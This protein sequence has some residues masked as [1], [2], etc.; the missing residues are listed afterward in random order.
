MESLNTTGTEVAAP[1]VESAPGRAREIFSALQKA[2]KMRKLYNSSGKPYEEAVGELSSRFAEYLSDEVALVVAVTLDA[3]VVEG[4][5]YMKSP[6]REGSIPFQLFRDGIRSIRILQGVP[7]EEVMALLDVLEFQ[8]DASHLDDDMAT[9]FWK[10]DFHAIEIT[11]FDDLGALSDVEGPGGEGR[12]ALGQDLGRSLEEVVESLRSCKLF[13]GEGRGVVRLAQ[14]SGGRLVGAEEREVLE[15]DRLGLESTQQEIDE[16]L[17]L[18]SEAVLERL[19]HELEV[20]TR[21]GLL[22]RVSDMVVHIL[23]EGQCT[24]PPQELS[25][26]LLNLTRSLAASGDVARINELLAKIDRRTKVAPLP[27]ASE[28]LVRLTEDL[29]TE[30]SLQVLFRGIGS[31]ERSNPSQLDA[32]FAR[33][34]ARVLAPCAAQMAHLKPGQARDVCLRLLKT[35]GHQD[36]RCLEVYLEKVGGE[37]AVN[38][39]RAIVESREISALGSALRRL[40]QHEDERV[41][42]DCVRTLTAVPGAGRHSLLELSLSDVSSKVRQVALRAIE[43]SGDRSLFSAL[44]AR[45]EACAKGDDDEKIRVLHAVAV[46]GGREALDFL[47]TTLYPQKSWRLIQSAWGHEEK[48]RKALAV[49]IRDIVDPAIREL[50]GETRKP[51]P[52][53]SEPAKAAAPPPRRSRGLGEEP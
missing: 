18:V 47:R 23:C 52:A 48:W 10:R 51:G 20:D 7:R 42:M 6:R 15:L 22:A 53:S 1:G 31:G 26:L 41:R 36:P 5:E 35:R 14:S 34:P 29:S 9:I 21:G 49:Q 4:E 17:F 30:E 44:K 24:L 19:R 2:L 16:D 12:R 8:P 50:L 45:F 37:E 32:L 25:T 11:V 13:G 39:V 3:F 38:D 27:T 46:L 40:L 33:L 43:Q 28:A